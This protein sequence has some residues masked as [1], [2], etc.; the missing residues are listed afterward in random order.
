MK[1]L[2]NH[3]KSKKEN[4]NFNKYFK[5]EK[6]I[7]DLSLKIHNKR[8]NL[9]LSQEELANKANITQQ[10]LSKIENGINC[11]LITYLKVCNALSLKISFK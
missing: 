2:S 10:Q 1:T 7:L 3:I 5:E 8:E 4:K 9:K 6:Q 11:N